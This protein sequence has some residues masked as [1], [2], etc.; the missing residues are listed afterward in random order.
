MQCSA[1]GKFWKSKAVF[2]SRELMGAAFVLRKL[3]AGISG[4][5]KF[6]LDDFAAQMIIL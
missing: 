5:F 1:T 6:Y 4:R 3:P 2:V